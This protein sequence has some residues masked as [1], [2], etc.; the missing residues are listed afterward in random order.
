MGKEVFQQF[1]SPVLRGKPSKLLLCRETPSIVNLPGASAITTQCVMTKRFT[2]R[3]CLAAALPMTFVSLGRKTQYSAGVSIIGSYK[4]QPLSSPYV[5]G[6]H[7]ALTPLIGRCPSPRH[8]VALF[9]NVAEKSSL[10]LPMGSN[11]P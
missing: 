4:V 6:R 10:T 2:D 11:S 1:Y 8:F 3:S 7:P 5:G 9:S